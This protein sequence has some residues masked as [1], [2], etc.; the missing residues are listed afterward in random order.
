MRTK[1]I[2]LPEDLLNKGL[3]RAKTDNRNFSSYVQK[4]IQRDLEGSL[5]VPPANGA[6]KPDP[7][8]QKELAI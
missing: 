2:S 1:T 3:E 5:T 8:K 7:S 4:L 6:A